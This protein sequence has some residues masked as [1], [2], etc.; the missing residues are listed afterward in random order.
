MRAGVGDARKKLSPRL[1]NDSQNLDRRYT[2]KH[3][4]RIYFLFFILDF[5][6]EVAF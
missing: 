4:N 5:S 1:E 6:P 3:T 2:A